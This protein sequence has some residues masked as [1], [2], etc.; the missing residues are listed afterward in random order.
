MDPSL[1]ATPAPRLLSLS[2]YL[3]LAQTHG[4]ATERGAKAGANFERS[5]TQA[6]PRNRYA[7]T[8]RR[9]HH[10]AAPG[11][12]LGRGLRASHGR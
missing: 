12:A 6:E 7:C 3:R 9:W 11:L 5:H 10:M 1:E 2:S 4:W 8:R